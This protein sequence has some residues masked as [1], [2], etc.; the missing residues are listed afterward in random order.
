[1]NLFAEKILMNLVYKNN[2]EEN[3]QRLIDKSLEIL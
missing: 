3:S 2:E 1:M